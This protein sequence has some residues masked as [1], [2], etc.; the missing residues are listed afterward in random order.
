MMPTLDDQMRAAL[1]P[2]A[3]GSMPMERFEAMVAAACRVKARYDGPEVVRM[4]PPPM[5]FQPHNRPA[6][7]PED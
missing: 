2:Y 1:L 5:P 4:S 7:N 6:F 3:G